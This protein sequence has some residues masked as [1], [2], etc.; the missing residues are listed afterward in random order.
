MSDAANPTETGKTTSRGR[1]TSLKQSIQNT[2]KKEGTTG[3]DT[4]KEEVTSIVV[5]DKSK[6]DRTKTSI[7]LYQKNLP[8]NRPIASGSFEVWEYVK[9]GGTRP[10]AV[11]DLE[12]ST[13]LTLMGNRPI[14]ISHNKVDHLFD[15]RPVM[16]NTLKVHEM[17]KAS[18][19]R[20]IEVSHLIISQLY[21]LM[22]N[23]PIASNDIDD[24]EALMGFI[25]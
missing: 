18:G 10:I 6:S 20:P 11:S 13:S 14:E 21:S 2:V 17:F 12:I 24:P 15:G 9:D 19:E 7:Q 4:T 22:G 5:Q 16:T 23:R 3:A 8:E 1:R 25:D